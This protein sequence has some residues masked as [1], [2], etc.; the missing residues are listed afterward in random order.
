ML[1]R[2]TRP[3]AT[4]L[5]IGRYLPVTPANQLRKQLVLILH[6]YTWSAV[7]VLAKKNSWALNLH[8]DYN[9]KVNFCI[10]AHFRFYPRSHHDPLIL[11]GFQ[12]RFIVCGFAN[13]AIV[14]FCFIYQIY[15]VATIC[16]NE[17]VLTPIHLIYVNFIQ[18]NF[19][20]STP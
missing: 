4:I 9:A 15:C 8:L 14:F 17:L 19:H 18:P 2:R 11:F 10:T 16:V 1:C 20:L 5:F 12:S 3:C 7:G 13:H 6:S